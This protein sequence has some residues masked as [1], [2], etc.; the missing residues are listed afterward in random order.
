MAL[1][2][3]LSL[4]RQL[5]PLDRR[6][7]LLYLEDL[8][9]AIPIDHDPRRIGATMIR[10]NGA[11]LA[12]WVFAALS[13]VVM[14]FHTAAILGAPVGDLTMGGQSDDGSAGRIREQFENRSA[15]T[16]RKTTKHHAPESRASRQERE[17]DEICK[18]STPGSNP[19]GASN[20][21]RQI[22]V[23]GMERWQERARNCSRM[24]SDFVAGLHPQSGKSLK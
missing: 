17:P 2:R 8:D 14:L 22:C 23:V 4:I 15:Q 10:G 1:E 12:A 13:V 18:T 6:V 7:M 3:L 5:E 20:F 9:A 19:G 24:F 16:R 21:P 11:R